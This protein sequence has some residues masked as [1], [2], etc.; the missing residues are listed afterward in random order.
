MVRPASAHGRT[1][2]LT[3]TPAS[4]RRRCRRFP[5]D[6]PAP[7]GALH[8]AEIEYALGNL[9]A[10]P[11]YRW[12]AE[13]RQVS[14]TMQGYFIAFIKTGDPNAPGLPHWLPAQPGDGPLPRQHIDVETRSEPFG[15]Q[16]RCVAA[17]PLLDVGGR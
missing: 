3:T 16:A 11:L 9:D 1:D 12:T 14:A 13:D 15:W 4:A 2:L 6:G 8:S 10:N 5:I 17:V 7:V